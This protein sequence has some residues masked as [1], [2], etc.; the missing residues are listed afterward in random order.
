M[1]NVEKPGFTP[2]DF[3]SLIGHCSILCLKGLIYY[4]NF[5]SIKLFQLELEIQKL[6]MFVPYSFQILRNLILHERI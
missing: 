5:D 2:Q 3:K 6:E 1:C 4:Y